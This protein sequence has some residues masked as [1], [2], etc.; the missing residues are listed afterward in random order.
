MGDIV[1]TDTVSGMFRDVEL[2]LPQPTLRNVRLK[3]K[4]AS[5]SFPFCVKR[6][7]EKSYTKVCA[8]TRRHKSSQLPFR[9][10]FTSR[11]DST[12]YHQHMLKYLMAVTAL[13]TLL[14]GAQTEDV[15]EANVIFEAAEK[16][17]SL[18]VLSS[19]RA[20]KRGVLPSTNTITAVCVQYNS[21]PARGGRGM[22]EGS[23]WKI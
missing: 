11:P 18:S 12:V 13:Q 9:P 7:Q 6:E 8:W 17:E 1:I 15:C 19:G 20:G 3:R 2:L 10:L 21:T 5:Q 16:L 4:F 14:V 22:R 23:Q